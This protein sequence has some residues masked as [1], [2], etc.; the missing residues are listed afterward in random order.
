M[1]VDQFY[2]P[3]LLSV[4]RW[5]DNETDNELKKVKNYYFPEKR[6]FFFIKRG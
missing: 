4:C 2:K 5:V 3:R 6:V 1:L